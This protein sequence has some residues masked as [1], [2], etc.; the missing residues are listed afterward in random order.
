MS[1]L[2]AIDGSQG[3]GG[4]Q[5]LRTSLGL[6]LVTGRPVRI[7]RIRAARSNPG[8]QRQHLAA[9]RAAIEV[10]A[11]R[12]DGAHLGSSTLTF[13][14]E[15]VR[16]G[17]YLFDVGSAGSATLVLQTVLPALALADGPS[18]VEIT[19]GTHNA[20]APPFEFLERVFLPL[21]NRMGPQVDVRLERHGFYPAGQ[22]R[23]L[24]EIRPAPAWEGF[25]L[26][27]RGAFVRGS[28]RALVSRLPEHVGRR[29]V[30]TALQRLARNKA[31][32][33]AWRGTVEE[34]DAAGSGN[35]VLVE[36]VHEHAVEVFA[37]FGK[38]GVPAE[39]VALDAADE[40]AAYLA[41]EVPIGP[42]L[43]DQLLLPL[44][45]S[46]WQARD[47]TRRRG[48]S[49][50]TGPP[51]GHTT[52]HVELL[53]RLLDLEIGVEERDPSG[54]ATIRVAPRA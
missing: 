3:E 51:S 17:A 10:G 20:W 30:E 34:V 21:L 43:A 48:G 42:H 44:G 41:S 29:E 36:V 37:G 14:P 7:E 53:R 5:I 28:V 31:R 35:A 22:G 38:R 47:G 16:S 54:S 46:A 33:K 52:T 23:L 15:P 4:G 40:A 45:I 12:A 39:K 9:V 2:V 11:A 19:G 49:F 8:L 18:R 27:D 25:D 50:L 6:S 1:E 32:R 26:L 24:A 13:A